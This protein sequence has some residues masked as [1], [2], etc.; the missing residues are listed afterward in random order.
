[1]YVVSC[2]LDKSVRVW[3]PN[4]GQEVRRLVAGGGKGGGTIRDVVFSA[5]GKHV[6][7]G[8][9][10]SVL[11]VWD[12]TTGQEV[13]RLSAAGGGFPKGLAAGGLSL[14]SDAKLAL[15]ANSGDNG[16]TVWDVTTG[17]QV[18]VLQG[19]T[20]MVSGVAISPDG[21]RAL[22][23]GTDG[24]VRLWDVTTGK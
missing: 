20:N 22:S 17:K 15:S 6:L 7:T 1:K 4:T 5:D 10:T 18:R 9:S 3:D 8:G 2:S 21:K 16:I 12:V 19:H 24:T 14:S 11:V 13:R 23:S